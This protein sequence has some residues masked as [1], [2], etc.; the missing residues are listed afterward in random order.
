MKV[1]LGIHFENKVTYLNSDRLK[2]FGYL[3]AR[4]HDLAE[5][6]IINAIETPMSDIFFP[7]ISQK[8]ECFFGNT[9]V[10]ATCINNSRVLLLVPCS[11]F[12]TVIKH[13][14]SFK[15]PLF[16]R[17]HPVRSIRHSLNFLKTIYSSNNL[18]RVQTTKNSIRALR[19]FRS[20]NAKA[21]NSLIDELLVF[22]SPHIVEISS[23]FLWV[24]SKSQNAIDIIQSL[25][26][27]KSK[28]IKVSTSCLIWI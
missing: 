26:L 13:I 8:V 16:D 4:L 9:E 7:L 12:F 11:E 17:V 6:V 20:C 18:I 25:G 19:R 2:L 3:G 22:K 23:F 24:N 28:E 14:S 1:E 21:H 27:V 10:R 15:S 5:V